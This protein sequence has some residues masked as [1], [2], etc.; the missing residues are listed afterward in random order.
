ML[1][2]DRWEFAGPN[3]ALDGGRSP[4]SDLASEFFEISID[5]ALHLFYPDN[6]DTFTFGGKI[7]GGNASRQE[8][9]ANIRAFVKKFE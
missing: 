2:P 8:V 7:L 9:A 3:L 1:W 5:A 6:Q 4:E